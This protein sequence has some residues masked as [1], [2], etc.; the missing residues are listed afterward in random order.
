MGRLH[1]RSLNLRSTERVQ[2]LELVQFRVQVICVA[3]QIFELVLLNSSLNH[4]LCRSPNLMNSYW[5]VKHTDTVTR[6][7]SDVNKERRR[8][9]ETKMSASATQGSYNE[10]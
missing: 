5:L 1:N 7:H 9:H 8:N 2:R 10:S 3:Q 4:D 6:R